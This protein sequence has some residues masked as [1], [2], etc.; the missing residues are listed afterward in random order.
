MSRKSSRKN[1]K[2][3]ATASIWS[4]ATVMLAVCIPLIPV[5]QSGIALPLLVIFG[6][7][8]STA[9]VWLSS[10]QLRK[11]EL[12]LA[13]RVEVLEERIITLET[14]CIDLLPGGEKL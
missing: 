6:A 10:E 5:T 1:P 11:E 14:I 4:V 12:R 2:V 7:G 8:G 9:A 3:S 13:R